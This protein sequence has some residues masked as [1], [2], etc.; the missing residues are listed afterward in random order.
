[1]ME[2]QIVD[3]LGDIKAYVRGQSSVSLRDVAAKVID[4]KEEAIV[5]SKLDG[6]RT[7]LEL[8]RLVKVPRKTVTNW[9]NE[10]VNSNLATDVKGSNDK[11]LFT[12]D[13]LNI[14]LRTL[15]RRSKT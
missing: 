8:S 7:H 10:F 9:V 12:L 3:L 4:V 11:A 14:S 5:Y 2:K 15:Q 13:E 6:T 1:M